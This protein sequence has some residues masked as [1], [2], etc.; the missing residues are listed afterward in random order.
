VGCPTDFF[1][2]LKADPHPFTKN[3]QFPDP[4]R[5]RGE[6]SLARYISFH[7]KPLVDAG[8]IERDVYAMLA[9]QV[10]ASS[11]LSHSTGRYLLPVS[12]LKT[13]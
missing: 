9:R 13:H 2:L 4:N 10:E 3:L 8:M 1:R 6:L 5:E 7:A 11:S 12:S